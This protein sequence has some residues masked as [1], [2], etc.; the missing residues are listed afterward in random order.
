MTN[1]MDTF[2]NCAS[3]I[4]VADILEN[5]GEYLARTHSI[6]NELKRLRETVDENTASCVDELL[7]E[8]VVIDELRQYACFRAGFRLALE[9]TR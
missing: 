8:Q 2:Y 6:E 4:L 9:L 3:K 5:D 7:C 1:L